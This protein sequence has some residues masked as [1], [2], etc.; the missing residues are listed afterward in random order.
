MRVLRLLAATACAAGLTFGLAPT[1]NAGIIKPVPTERCYPGRACFYYN[2]GWQGALA[3]LT[4]VAWWE[5]DFVFAPGTGNGA[6]KPV[7]NAAASADNRDESG[8]YC[9]HYNSGWKGPWEYVPAQS[10]LIMETTKNNNASTNWFPRH[11]D[12]GGH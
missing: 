8:A 12:G 7:K 5:I 11:Q 6:G 10:R 1:A 4:T 3:P 2:S 9:I